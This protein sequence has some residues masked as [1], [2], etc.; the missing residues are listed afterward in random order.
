MEA[1]LWGSGEIAITIIGRRL[2]RRLESLGLLAMT[3]KLFV[4]WIIIARHSR[5]NLSLNTLWK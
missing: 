4:F 5:G 2:L 3:L 1:D